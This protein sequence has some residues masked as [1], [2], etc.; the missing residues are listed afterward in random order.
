MTSSSR[1]LVICDVAGLRPDAATVEVL[2]RLQVAARRRGC[3]LRLCNAS[4]E[5]VEL[6][7]FMGLRE[8]LLD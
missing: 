7:T 8:V 3:Q 5:L 6:V 4:D 2:A 1:T